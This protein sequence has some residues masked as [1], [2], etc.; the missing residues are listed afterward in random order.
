MEKQRK[1]SILGT[2]Y[3][4]EKKKYDEEPDFERRSID[5]Y[6]DQMLKTLVYCDMKTYPGFENQ[7]QEYCEACEKETLRH[8]IIHAF[9][10]ESGLMESSAQFQGGWS[11]NE[12]MVDWIAIQSPKILKVFEEV[13][14]I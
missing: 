8:E 7:S 1:I 14:C 4:I 3:V 12:E 10:G 5:G 2:E 11:K 6:C 13:G 9:L